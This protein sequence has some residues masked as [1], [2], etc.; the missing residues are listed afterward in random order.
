LASSAGGE[1]E[2]RG[3]DDVRDAAAK[4]DEVTIWPY[5]D[6]AGRVSLI[7][8]RCERTLRDAMPI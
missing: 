7:A 4:I 1:P 8:K 2:V 3:I 5:A 6:S